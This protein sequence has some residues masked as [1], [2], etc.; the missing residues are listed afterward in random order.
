MVN[1]VNQHLG[2]ALLKKAVL[3]E[4]LPMM[5]MVNF[6]DTNAIGISVAVKELFRG[7]LESF[8]LF[9]MQHS[10]I[11]KSIFNAKMIN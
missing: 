3:P 11:E 2:T 10:A 7:T 6:S 9:V 1:P 5:P 4:D 8:A